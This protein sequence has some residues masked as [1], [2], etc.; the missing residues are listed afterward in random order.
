MAR[1]LVSAKSIERVTLISPDGET[2]TL[3]RRKGKKSRQSLPLKPLEK[4]QKTAVEAVREGADAYLKGHKRS[5]EKKKD[6]WAKDLADNTW[7]ANT[8]VIRK[9]RK[10]GPK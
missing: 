5:N 4:A 2:R 8:R 9:L 6:G 10:S 7:K 3:F 1:N